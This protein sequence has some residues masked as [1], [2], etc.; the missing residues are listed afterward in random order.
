MGSAPLAYLALVIPE[1]DR[2]AGDSTAKIRAVTETLYD[3]LVALGCTPYVKTI[4]IGF[5]Y[6][7]ELVAALYPHPN[8]VEVAL[9]LPED[10]PH[11]LLIDATHLT[12][13]SMPVAAVVRTQAE[14]RQ[15][16]SLLGD[17]FDGVASGRH[18]VD[19]PNER[20]TRRPKRW[21]Q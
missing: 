20:F 18:D 12:W 3:A 16:L 19:L 1:A 6:Q 14:A 2:L 17:A 8:R 13:R 11:P 7:G 10:H 9:A 21:S 4:Y 15:A 5:E